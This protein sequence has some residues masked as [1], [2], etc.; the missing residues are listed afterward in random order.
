MT[1]KKGIW[2]MCMLMALIGITGCGKSS[3]F[4]DL[5]GGG[6]G[7]DTIVDKMD[8][9]L[10]ENRPAD[11]LSLANQVLSTPQTPTENKKKA[12]ATKGAAILDLNGSSTSAISSAITAIKNNAV[13]KNIVESLPPISTKNA[14]EAAIALNQAATLGSLTTDQQ[15]QRSV[16]N[17]AVVGAKVKEVFDVS[18]EGVSLKPGSSIKESLQ[19]LFT[20]DSS[21]KTIPDYA[22]TASQAYTNANQSGDGAENLSKISDISQK[23]LDLNSAIQSSGSFIYTDSNGHTQVITSSSSDDQV[24]SAV[25]FQIRRV[26]H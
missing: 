26:N 8:T 13:T 19:D 5:S 22:Q 17:A 21:S 14:T 25:D 9:A 4:R 24:K 1:F 11:A 16:A 23:L 6:S 20:P 15:L 2:A 18:S 10:K 12:Y 7:G 3:V